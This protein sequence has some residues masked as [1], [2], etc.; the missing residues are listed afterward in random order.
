[1]TVA[2][3][4]AALPTP[5]LERQLRCLSCSGPV[6]RSLMVLGSLRCLA[7]REANAPLDPALFA[8]PRTV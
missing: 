3:G 6:E 8:P 7:C 2:D 5:D 1:M 4:T